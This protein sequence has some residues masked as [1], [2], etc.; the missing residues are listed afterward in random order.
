MLFYIQVIQQDLQNFIYELCSIIHYNGLGNPKPGYYVFLKI[1]GTFAV[2]MFTSASS[3]IHLVKQST[4]MIKY[5]ICL[6]AR[7]NGSRVPCPHCK[8]D[9][10]EVRICSFVDGV[11]K[12]S[13]CH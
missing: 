1:I 11:L 12:T 10:G 13:L 8:N 3:S 5:M 2:V 4:S 9:H 7:A 6:D